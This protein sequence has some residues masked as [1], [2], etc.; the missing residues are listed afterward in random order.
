MIGQIEQ[1]IVK[2]IDD[3]A[4]Q[5][6]LG[7]TLRKIASYGGEFTDDKTIAEVV[8]SYPCALVAF[9][10]YSAPADV[11]ANRWEYEPTFAVMVAAKSYRNEAATRQGAGTEVGTYQMLRDI[12]ALIGEQRLGLDLSAP[13]R[14]GRLVTLF[15]GQLQAQRLSIL[16]Q[17]FTCKFIEESAAPEPAKPI[18][19]LVTFHADWDV[20]VFT[21]QPDDKLP[22]AREKR[23]A[24]DTVQLPQS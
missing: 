22:L 24:E 18:G 16:S 20:P 2:H 5:N 11:G 13:F 9:T 1:A 15:N 14:P 12:R 6:L 10:G 23:D 4:R 19:D 7:W 8:K 3:A 17:E 21:T